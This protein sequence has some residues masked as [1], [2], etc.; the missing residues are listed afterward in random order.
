MGYFI[1]ISTTNHV[2]EGIPRPGFV[3]A[4]NRGDDSSNDR[5]D[6]LIEKAVQVQVQEIG[7]YYYAST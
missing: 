6:P 2:H 5:L 7:T 4:P 1:T 3:M